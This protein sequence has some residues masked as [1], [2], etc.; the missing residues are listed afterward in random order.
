LTD[1]DGITTPLTVQSTTAQALNVQ[2]PAGAALGGA[3]ITITAGTAKYFGTLFVDSQDNVPAV[4]GCTYQVNAPLDDA[5]YGASIVSVLVVTQA[6]CP[7]HVVAGS[8]FVT[9]P[10][11]TTGTA[12][13][14][15]TFAANLGSTR[16]AVIEVAGQPITLTQ[17]GITAGA[18]FT[19]PSLSGA[20]IRAV[21]IAELR[22]RI[23]AL[24]A[25]RSL[26]VFGWSDPMVVAS[27]TVVR[28]LHVQELRTALN[29][30][31]AAVNRAAP[32]YSDPTIVAG[33]TTIR[34]VHI[35]E[36]RSAVIAL[37]IS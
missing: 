21:H 26:P 17:A 24:R 35:A 20:R 4:N 3:Y 11:G 13:V 22:A 14:P 1:A 16:N 5:S 19:D 10:P 33:S 31:Y 8:N 15:L 12:V 18:P 36:L 32:K 23:D 27:S 34:A 28:A 37:E 25:A 30:A 9:P 2:L 6:G 7:H 29:D